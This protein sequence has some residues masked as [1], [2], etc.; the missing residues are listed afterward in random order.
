MR[1]LTLVNLAIMAAPYELP[2]Y[3]V[4]GTG[5]FASNFNDFIIHVLVSCVAVNVSCDVNTFTM[6]I[7]YDPH[8]GVNFTTGSLLYAFGKGRDLACTGRTVDDPGN[9]LCQ[10]GH[11]RLD[12]PL[13]SEKRDRCGTKRLM[14]DVS[15]AIKS[16]RPQYASRI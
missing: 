9:G 4:R 8:D 2:S 10:A 16:S 7:C 3:L 15:R 14:A 11:V 13:D 6:R 12:L 1:F 5:I